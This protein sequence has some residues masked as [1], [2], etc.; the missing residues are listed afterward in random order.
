MILYRLVYNSSIGKIHSRLIYMLCV[1]GMS[2]VYQ[3]VRGMLISWSRTGAC[4]SICNIH[5]HFLRLVNIHLLRLSARRH[6][7]VLRALRSFMRV[8]P[9]IWFQITLHHVCKTV[10][11]YV[12]KDTNKSIVSEHTFP[13][14]T[15]F[16]T[17][18]RTTKLKD[19]FSGQ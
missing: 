8:S 12:R 19:A 9:R 13:E 4:I 2:H 6:L 11:N 17:E 10:N 16:S 15:F 5:I 18:D 7:G 1:G 3:S 14:K